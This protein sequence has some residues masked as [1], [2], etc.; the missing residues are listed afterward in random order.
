[1]IQVTHRRVFDLGVTQYHH[2]VMVHHLATVLTA[3]GL[4]PSIVT[5]VLVV[6][7]PIRSTFPKPDFTKLSSPPPSAFVLQPRRGFSNGMKMP[8]LDAL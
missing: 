5:Q 3:R 7:K 4:E 8:V 6:L 1:M 2:D